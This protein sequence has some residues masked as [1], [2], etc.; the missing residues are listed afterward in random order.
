MTDQ[1]GAP[2]LWGAGSG[3]ELRSS[4]NDFAHS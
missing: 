3:G 1:G 4:D 2:F